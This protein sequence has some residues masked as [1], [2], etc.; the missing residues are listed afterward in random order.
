MYTMV[1]VSKRKG[2]ENKW[3]KRLEG[4]EGLLYDTPNNG[5]NYNTWKTLYRKFN[6]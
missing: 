1:Y 5:V 6:V 4:R 2:R 3:Y